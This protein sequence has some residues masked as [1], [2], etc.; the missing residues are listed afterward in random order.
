MGLSL[1]MQEK[2]GDVE[3]RICISVPAGVE[4]SCT[5]KE[6]VVVEDSEG[7]VSRLHPQ[8]LWTKGRNCPGS[9]SRK[10]QDSPEIDANSTAGR[11]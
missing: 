3:K 2:E 7:E 1:E 8:G 10:G 11:R 9:Q 6:N 4:R 5:P